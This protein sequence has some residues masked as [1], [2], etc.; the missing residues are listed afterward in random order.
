MTHKYPS[1][2]ESLIDFWLDTLKFVNNHP[3]IE[4]MTEWEP[5][6]KVERGYL[7]LVSPLHQFK[8]HEELRDS[9]SWYITLRCL[10]VRPRGKS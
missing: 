3:E 2:R 10:K 7:Y 6:D 5:G 9:G 4:D 8:A 1:R